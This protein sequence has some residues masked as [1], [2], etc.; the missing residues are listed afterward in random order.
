MSVSVAEALYLYCFSH[1]AYRCD[2]CLSWGGDQQ[3]NLSKPSRKQPSQA[4]D[5]KL[6]G[7]LSH[8]VSEKTQSAL[9]KEQ[10]WINSPWCCQRLASQKYV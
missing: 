3:Q 2:L 6:L 7:V 8:V 1:D 5:G 10:G 9:R 4:I